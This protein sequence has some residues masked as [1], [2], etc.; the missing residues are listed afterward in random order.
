MTFTTCVNVVKCSNALHL[1]KDNTTDTIAEIAYKSG[2][3]SIRNFNREFKKIYKVTPKEA[4]DAKIL[5]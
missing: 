2:F 5:I 4:F 3:G 1:I